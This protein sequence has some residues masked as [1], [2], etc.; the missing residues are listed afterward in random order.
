MPAST[1]RFMAKTMTLMPL[2]LG[3]TGFAVSLLPDRMMTA[4]I[5]WLIGSVPLGIATGS[6]V[7]DK[8]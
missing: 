4:V 7:L 1:A 8:E 2:L 6:F 5:L 3:L